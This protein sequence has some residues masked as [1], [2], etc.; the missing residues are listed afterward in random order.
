MHDDTAIAGIGATEFSQAS[1]RKELQLAA[2]PVRDP[3]RTRA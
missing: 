3:S 2:E 1:G